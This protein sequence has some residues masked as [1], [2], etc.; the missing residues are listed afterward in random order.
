MRKYII[1]LLCA[2]AATT[3]YAQKIS[4]D[5]NSHGFRIITTTRE[6][7]GNFS[8]KMKLFVGMSLIIPETGEKDVYELDVQVNCA[9][10]LEIRK[11]DRMLI[12]TT[13][14]EVV[15]LQASADGRT[16][17]EKLQGIIF[18]Q[19]INSYA[20]TP[21][22]AGLLAKGVVKVRIEMA[23]EEIYEKEWKSDKCGKVIGNALRLLA[24]AAKTDRKSSFEEDF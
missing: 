3:G 4:G 11:G 1:A 10:K 21:E 8:D 19:A 14:G 6:N 12:K 17:E 22:Q 5:N 9:K 15:R 13:S 7:V 23:G 24:E 2:F 16:A 18:F 20:I